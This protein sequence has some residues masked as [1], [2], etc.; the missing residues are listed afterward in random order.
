[1]R[2]RNV[3]ALASTALVL[4]FAG[5]AA[6]QPIDQHGNGAGGEGPAGGEVGG[7]QGGGALPFT[8]LEVG[9]VLLGGAGITAT[10]LALRRSA[11]GQKR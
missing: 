5:G 1:V 9:L 4:S 2:K 8:G 7:E 10:G 11:R 3:A 6:A